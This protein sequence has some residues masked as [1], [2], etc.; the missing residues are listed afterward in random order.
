MTQKL[1]WKENKD[2]ENS[3]IDTGLQL[4]IHRWFTKHFISDEYYAR[5]WKPQ[6]MG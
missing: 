2:Q 5:P 1:S 4:L 6:K 3:W